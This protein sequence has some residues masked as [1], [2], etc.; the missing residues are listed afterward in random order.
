M[1]EQRES[2]DE[3]QEHW[4]RQN[5]P[6]E[7]IDMTVEQVLEQDRKYQASARRSDVLAAVGALVF[8]PLLL[9]ASAT[10]KW[11]EVRAGYGLMAVGCGITA[12]ALWLY[13]RLNRHAPGRD[14]TVRDHL[15]Q[16]VAF[17][18]RQATLLRTSTLWCG[19]PLFLGVLLFG[20]G[21][22]IHMSKLV[23]AL[24]AGGSLLP[25][26]G[27]WHMNNGRKMRQIAQRRTRAEDLLRR[28]A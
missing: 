14:L 23:G 19:L 17:L 21:I 24:F 8:L 7:N 10:G 12:V 26:I 20:A 9:L 16:S 15:E 5:A 22:W 11:P 28:L 4:Q 6:E 13:H 27:S 2:P 3:L 18:E 1:S 25:L